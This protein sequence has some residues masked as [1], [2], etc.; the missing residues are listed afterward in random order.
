MQLLQDTRALPDQGSMSHRSLLQELLLA[1]VGFNGDVFLSLGA[2]QAAN[3]GT[4]CGCVRAL[5][6][7]RI[8]HLL[9]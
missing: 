2:P 9:P 8:D 7:L 6:W 3:A 1:L 4:R 5:H